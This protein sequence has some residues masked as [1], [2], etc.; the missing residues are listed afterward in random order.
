[1]SFIRTGRAA[2]F[3][4]AVLVLAA[5][6]Q[7]PTAPAASALRT[8]GERVVN[9]AFDVQEATLRWL[10]D[11]KSATGLDAQCVSTGFPD[12]DNDPSPLLL[13]R[14]AANATPVVPL[15]SCTVD[16]S[17]ITYNPTGGFAQWFKL[18]EP[19]ISGRRATLPAAMQLNGRLYEGYE[20]QA[21]LQQTWTITN[22]EL[23]VAG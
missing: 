10:I 13:D 21:R 6:E 23:V 7:Q 14:F 20:C 22:C 12:F 3:A 11:N 15:S 1:M 19:V 5:C 8:G 2:S 4:A 9:P 17:G 18:G 16:V